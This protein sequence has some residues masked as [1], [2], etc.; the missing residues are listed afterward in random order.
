SGYLFAPPVKLV[1]FDTLLGIPE[2][3]HTIG[4]PFV[5]IGHEGVVIGKGIKVRPVN[6]EKLT[7]RPQQLFDAFV[8]GAKPQIDK[9]G[10]EPGDEV[11]ESGLK[12]KLRLAVPET[13]FQ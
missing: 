1:N 11:L 9:L 8:D 4:A 5:G 2:F 7:D 10:R 3:R 6:L 12:G 13:L